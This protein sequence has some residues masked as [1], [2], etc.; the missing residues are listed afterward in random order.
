MRTWSSIITSRMTGNIFKRPGVLKPCTVEQLINKQQFPAVAESF[1]QCFPSIS[2]KSA[3]MFSMTDYQIM[4]EISPERFKCGRSILPQNGSPYDV[5]G[6][7]SFSFKRHLKRI[8]ILLKTEGQRRRE[9]NF[10]ISRD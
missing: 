4:K 10:N 3:V 6:I 1:P 5:I 8:L 2:F 7:V 9:D